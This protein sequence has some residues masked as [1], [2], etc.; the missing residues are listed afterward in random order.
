M[1]PLDPNICQSEEISPPTPLPAAPNLAG[2]R[3]RM[4]C[5]GLLKGFSSHDLRH[6]L[7]VLGEDEIDMHD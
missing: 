7:G 5:L 4:M 3:V 2:K 1:C 6:G